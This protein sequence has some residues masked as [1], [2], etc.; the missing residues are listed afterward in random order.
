MGVV[1]KPLASI[2]STQTATTKGTRDPSRLQH[3]NFIYK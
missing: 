1:H 3:Q 2:S